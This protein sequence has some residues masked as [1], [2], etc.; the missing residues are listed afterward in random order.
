MPDT[1]QHPTV[2]RL[3]QLSSLRDLDQSRLE[4]LAPQ[5]TIQAAKRKA[6]L[7]D[8]GATD[9]CTF[10][11]LDGECRLIA[12]DGAEKV[13]RHTEPSAQAPLAR[14]HMWPSASTAGSA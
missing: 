10:Y 13:I 7:L 6:V 1:E 5:L 14:E 4:A 11:L 12:E 3:K 9:D 8:I 2:D